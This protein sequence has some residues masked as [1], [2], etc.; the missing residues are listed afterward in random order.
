MKPEVIAGIAAVVCCLS[1]SGVGSYFIMNSSPEPEPEPEP[2][3]EKKVPGCMNENATNYNP[4]AT[5]DD[6]TCIIKGCMNKNATN[7]NP[8]ATKDDGTCIIKGCTDSPAMNYNPDAEED[9]GSC[10]YDRKAVMKFIDINGTP[11]CWEIDDANYFRM[12]DCSPEL[13][14]AELDVLTNSAGDITDV[15]TCFYQ[16]YIPDKDI[17]FHKA[18]PVPRNEDPDGNKCLKY[19]VGVGG[20][21]DTINDR[22]ISVY[23]LG[24]WVGELLRTSEKIRTDPLWVPVNLELIS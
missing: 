7:Y 13:E 12:A 23:G 20:D 14:Q 11:V 9:D 6:G 17:M 8:S 10:L 4:S 3:V 24:A 15:K 2:E 22:P 18:V 21:P 16:Y 19:K 5:K 1:S